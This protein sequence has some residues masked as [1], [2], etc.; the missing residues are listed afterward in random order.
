IAESAEPIESV[1]PTEPAEPTGSAKLTE[2]AEPT[3]LKDSKDS[4][5]NNHTSDINNTASSSVIF[6]NNPQAFAAS[7]KDSVQNL[8]K[9]KS[10]TENSSHQDI[11][12]AIQ[13]P[14]YE[15]RVIIPMQLL[16]AGVESSLPVG[17]QLMASRLLDGLCLAVIS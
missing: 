14:I 15:L 17:L 13:V 6:Q 11:Q 2:P 9:L 3:D 4:N 10:E 8:Q 12:S 1:R 7:L 16:E 5:N